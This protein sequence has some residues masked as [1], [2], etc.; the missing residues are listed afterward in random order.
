MYSSRFNILSYYNCSLLIFNTLSNS[1]FQI[2]DKE[3]IE[4]FSHSKFDRIPTNKLNTLIEHG[5]IIENT[6][7]EN[8]LARQKFFDYV[9]DGELQLVIIPTMQCNFRC[10]YCYENFSDK[11]MTENSINSLIKYLYKVLNRY[12]GLVIEWFGG[13]PLLAID[14]MEKITYQA[15]QLCSNLKIPFHAYIS[16]N[17]YLLNSNT[18][19]R[20]LKMRIYSIQITIDGDEKN[21]NKNRH[22]KDGRSTFN[23]I[24]ENLIY[25][26][27]NIKSPYLQILIRCNL[28]RSS[29]KGLPHFISQLNFLFS[30]DK[31]FKFYFQ[32]IEDWGGTSIDKYKNDLFDNP[33]ILFEMLLKNNLQIEIENRFKSLDT[34]AICKSVRKNYFVIDPE[35]DVYKCTVF[36][37]S[38]KDKIGK[39]KDGYIDIDCRKTAAWTFD[40]IK[41]YSFCA[42]KCPA[43][44]NCYAKLCPYKM[45]GNTNFECSNRVETISKLLSIDF[46]LSPEKYRKL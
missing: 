37:D 16:T 41:N 42:E 3:D 23:T 26:R 15:L 21:H 9:Y 24:L 10:E 20:L 17:G 25:I 44:A 38:H 11:F 13:E 7:D 34:M 4:N 1:F 28:S 18:I 22:L 31:R 46:K 33:N 30:K 39:I 29:L 36:M 12:S 2:K 5:I 19:K 14:Q 27:D 45:N 35:L 6:T 40:T 8:L 32:P 43:V